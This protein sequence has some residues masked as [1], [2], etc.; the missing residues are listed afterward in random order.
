M[1][2]ELFLGTECINV[3]TDKHG[4]SYVCNAR[5]IVNGNNIS[6]T[7]EADTLDKAED[8]AKE[9]LSIISKE[10]ETRDNYRN[11]NSFES[12]SISKDF[13]KGGGNK[14]ASDRQIEAIRSL[15]QRNG[16]CAKDIVRE[17]YN[18]RL[19]QLIGSEADEMIKSFTKEQYDEFF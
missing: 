15:S 1:K 17:R 9:K 4:K 2:D 6:A 14:K 5:G 3:L 18:K 7:A 11:D 16:V 10:L 19:D 13:L 12:R 8:M